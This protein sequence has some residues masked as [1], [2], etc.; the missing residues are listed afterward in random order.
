MSDIKGE[1]DV[2]EDL[3]CPEGDYIETAAGAWKEVIFYSLFKG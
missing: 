3:G 2:R 1:G